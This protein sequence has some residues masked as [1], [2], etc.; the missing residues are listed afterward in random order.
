MAEACNSCGA[1]IVFEAGKQS[2]TCPFCGVVNQVARPEDALE[3]SF[4]RIVPITVTPHELDNRLYAYMAS[5]EFTPDDMIEAST[6]TLRERYYVPAFAFKVDYEATW[7]ASFGFDRQEP[8]TAY[9]N[10][11]SNGHTRQ[12]AYTA[13]KTVT[14]WRP[15]NGVDSG[16]FDVAG[17]A[18]TQLNGSPLA[19]AN[20]V[21]HAV[22]NGSPTEYNPSFI[23][24]FE[25]EGFSVPEKIVFDS[26]NGEINTNIEKRVQNH[27]QGDKQRDWHWNARMSHDTTTYAVPICHG[28]FQYGDKVY[29]VWVGGHDVETIRADELPVDK[30]KLKTANI[31]FMP[32]ALGLVTAI[33]SAYYWSFVWFSLIAT[34]VALGYGFVRRKALI[35]YSKSIRNSLLIQMQASN[36]VANLS[37]EEQDKVAKAFQRPERPFFA[38]IHKDKIILPAVAAFAFFGAVVPNAV[39]NPAAISQRYIARQAAEQADQERRNA[40]VRVAQEAVD[41]KAAEEQASR[42][43][44]EEAAAAQKAE[45]EQVA[46][47][48][49]VAAPTQSQPTQEASPIPTSTSNL[50]TVAIAPAAVVPTATSGQIAISAGFMVVGPEE[51]KQLLTAMLQQATSAFKVSEIKG[52]IE[53][54]GKP[55]TGDRKAARKLNEQGLAALKSDD[56]AQALAA[57]KSATATDP[58]DVEILNNYVFALIKAKRL[59]DAETEAGRLLTISPG[60]SSAWANLAEVYALMNKNDEAVAALVLA[61]QFSSN[62]DRTV[63]FLNERAIDANSPIQATAK[64]TIE[65]IQKM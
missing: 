23:K 24:G 47:A 59:Q 55:A 14:D 64:K 10:V 38:Q 58:A 13:Y 62:K 41:R 27:A 11:T 56:F 3:T 12:E 7:T 8:Y 60:R 34:V 2:L 22:I 49:T 35:D 30:K 29:H 36:Q 61:F 40:E 15:A 45:A 18:G 43:A 50:N 20:L 5:G 31:G 1:E 53:T 19:P 54:F 44:Q 21:V 37:D 63:T 46:Q 4:D 9:R 16:I 52:K 57:L 26:L 6:I 28:A 39:L 65:I 17:Y 25:V 51:S 48:E 42:R 33:G 32:G